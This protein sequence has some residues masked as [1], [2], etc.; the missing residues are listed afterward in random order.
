MISSK[1]I[2]QN[3]LSGRHRSSTEARSRSRSR[4]RGPA[5]LQRTTPAATIAVE[6]AEPRRKP[7]KQPSK[8]INNLVVSDLYGNK[9]CDD[10]FETNSIGT[11]DFSADDLDWSTDLDTDTENDGI[12]K[13]KIVKI[14][15]TE[16]DWFEFSEGETDST[17]G[18]PQKVA[19]VEKKKKVNKQ[20]T[21]AQVRREAEAQALDEVEKSP[22]KNPERKR[23]QKSGK[24]S[25]SS[26]SS[27]GR[28]SQRGELA[29]NEEKD[30]DRSVSVRRSKENAKSTRG[31]ESHRN[32]LVDDEETDRDRSVSVRRSKEASSGRTLRAKSIGRRE[33]LKRTG[34]APRL[35][36]NV[37]LETD[38]M[39]T[40]MSSRSRSVSRVRKSKEGFGNRGR[41]SLREPVKVEKEIKSQKEMD[42]QSMLDKSRLGPMRDR[43]RSTSCVRDGSYRRSASDIPLAGSLENSK[44]GQS[45]HGYLPSAL[46]SPR[47]TTNRRSLL[48]SHIGKVDSSRLLT[49]S[50]TVHPNGSKLDN[51]ISDPSTWSDGGKPS[52]SV[53][54]SG[55]DLGKGPKMSSVDN[56]NWTYAMDDIL[57]LRT[58]RPSE[59]PSSHKA[60]LLS[61]GGRGLGTYGKQKSIPKIRTGEL[62]LSK[63]G[64]P[65]MN[66]N[67]MPHTPTLADSPPPAHRHARPLPAAL[68]AIAPT[69]YATKLADS[70]PPAHRHARALSATTPH[71]HTRTPGD[72]PPPAH[73]HARPLPATMHTSPR[74]L[75]SLR[76]GASVHGSSR[77]QFPNISSPPSSPH[78]FANTPLGTFSSSPR[79]N[80]TVHGSSANIQGLPSPQR[81]SAAYNGFAGAVS[82]RKQANEGA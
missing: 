9:S 33:H 10:S 7:R 4:S 69:K 29:D 64:R 41:S 50:A 54:L 40:S 56:N 8:N 47:R 45:G 2:L 55:A 67:G 17:T 35:P 34:A 28:E 81:H 32:K 42:H 21:S 13:P 18:G 43:S 1:E 15:D 48:A 37:P 22:K 53:S 49:S 27:R 74:K 6:T 80:S 59:S 23:R 71:Q 14:D 11:F 19:A 24:S 63:E 5:L 31:R 25:K 16:S 65:R 79:R 44:L 75:A 66:T 26:K 20:R 77:K 82:P 57:K 62:L 68:S 78:K 52:S 76:M 36:S 39:S 12:V 38:S 3:D 30:R 46:E 73:R 51:F 60:E 72:P 61:T 70:P 58:K